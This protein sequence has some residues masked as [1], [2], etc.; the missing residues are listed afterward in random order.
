MDIKHIAVCDDETE[1][2]TYLIQLVREWFLQQPSL[3]ADVKGFP[4][5]EAFLFEYEENKDWQLLVLDIEMKQMSGMSLAKKLRSEGNSVPIVFVTGY[6]DY[7]EEGYDVEALHYLMKP[8][9]VERFHLV[10][11]RALL[12][13]EEPRHIFET[14]EGDILLSNSSIWYAEAEGHYCTLYTKDKSYRLRCSISA[15]EKQLEGAGFEKPHRSYLVNLRHV[16][17]IKPQ[18]V[19]LDD[20][21]SIPLSRNVHRQFHMAFIKLYQYGEEK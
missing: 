8:L 11:N 1:Q 16:I 2:R 3:Y 6:D 7:M 20:E 5:A 4:S 21:R 9:S 17:L 19:I 12:T 13:K 10:L 14:A 15:L 18:E